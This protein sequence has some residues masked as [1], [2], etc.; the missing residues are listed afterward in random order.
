M[1]ASPNLKSALL[2]SL[3]TSLKLAIILF[4]SII[5]VSKLGLDT[6]IITA[7]VAIT[8]AGVMATV[9]VAIGLGARS[10]TANMI[11]NYH[12]KGMYQKGTEVT[13]AGHKG[14]VQEVSTVA[15]TLKTER[16]IITIP[17]DIALKQGSLKM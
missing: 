2:T 14:T 17:N 5:A 6:T 1:L 13:I 15:I 9:V 11:S 4:D 10:T 7:N 3:L 8:V 16:G 12:T